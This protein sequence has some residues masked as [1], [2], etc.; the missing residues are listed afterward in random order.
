MISAARRML[1]IAAEDV[2]LAY[3]QCMPIVKACVD[4][5]FQLGLPEASIPLGEAVILMATAPK[6]NSAA[7]AI[8]AAQADVR[9][10]KVGDIPAH[11]KDAHYSGAAKLGRGLA[12]QYPHDFPNHW[13]PQ[14]Y[15]PDELRDAHYYEYGPNKTEQAAK[16][17]WDRVKG[18]A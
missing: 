7:V 10:G 13:T 6:S 9:A 1:V 2:G 17:Y 12:Y 18:K 16:A 5:A 14:Q 3:P 4:S 15:L 11:I 8:G